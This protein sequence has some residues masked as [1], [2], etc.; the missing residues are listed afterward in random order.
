MHCPVRMSASFGAEET[1]ERLKGPD[2]K[3]PA[4]SQCYSMMQDVR[5]EFAVSY[6]T[7]KEKQDSMGKDQ[8]SAPMHT[9]DPNIQAMKWMK[10]RQCSYNDVQLSFWFY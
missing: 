6:S 5:K 2:P 3:K 8:S 1:T 4:K 10:E 9:V 7:L